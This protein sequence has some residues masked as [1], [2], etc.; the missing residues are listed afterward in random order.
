MS[1][2]IFGEFQTNAIETIKTFK[3]NILI[4]RFYFKKTTSSNIMAIIE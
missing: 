1:L 2:I 4:A 3:L